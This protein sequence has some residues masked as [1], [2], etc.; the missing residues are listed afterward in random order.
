[1]PELSL[2]MA[3]PRPGAEGEAR[4]GRGA[5]PVPPGLRRFPPGPAAEVAGFL[6]ASRGRCST[7]ATPPS[8][9]TPRPA[10]AQRWDPAGPGRAGG[11]GPR[12]RPTGVSGEGPGGAQR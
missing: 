7:G 9:L 6:P 1:M 12:Q 11:A 10:H 2:C 4:T 3:D 5:P 8:K